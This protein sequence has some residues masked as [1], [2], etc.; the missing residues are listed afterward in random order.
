MGQSPLTI[1]KERFLLATDVE[2]LD[3]ATHRIN[4][5]PVDKHS[6]NQLLYQQTTLSQY[7]LERYLIESAYTTAYL[8]LTR[9]PIWHY[10]Y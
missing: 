1:F 8:H 3:N 7:S 6:K 5:Y 9:I 4:H 10:C 2:M